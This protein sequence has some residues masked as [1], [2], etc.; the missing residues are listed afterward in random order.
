M[1]PT[2]APFFAVLACVFLL[3]CPASALIPTDL[4]Q[5][6]SPLSP[7]QPGTTVVFSCNY[8]NSSGEPVSGA[9]ANASL[10]GVLRA[11]GYSGGVYLYENSSIPVGAHYWR[12]TASKDGYDPAAGAPDFYE[13]TGAPPTLL[14]FA[15]A[16]GSTGCPFVSRSGQATVFVKL[17]VNGS[18]ACDAGGVR[19]NV[20]NP[21][22]ATAALAAGDCSGGVHSF[23]VSL[24]S[25]GRFVL[26]AYSLNA[27][28]PAQPV[29]C[30]IESVAGGRRA[31]PDLDAFAVAAALL[32]ALALMRRRGTGRTVF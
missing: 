27:S 5:A 20:T 2:A 16:D 24:A 9:S 7:Q 14:A 3:A 30:V 25:Q 4:T 18:A 23:N 29:Y 12:C 19:L 10:D 1:K 13:I 32:A 31:Y 26:A 6:A 15:R 8:T 28:Y 22:N 21:S 11:A 17:V